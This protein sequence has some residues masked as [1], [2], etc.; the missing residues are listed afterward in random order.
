MIKYEQDNLLP[1]LKR[2][3]ELTEQAESKL[4]GYLKTT[5][6]KPNLY[7]ELMTILYISDNIVEL[8]NPSMTTGEI[9]GLPKAHSGGSKYPVKV[10]KE[11]GWDFSQWYNE[12]VGNIKG[13]IK[14]AIYYYEIEYDK[15]NF[16][17]DASLGK[18]D[19]ILSGIKN[20]LNQVKIY[21]QTVLE[22][23]EKE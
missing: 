9:F 1:D 18:E 14:R 5:Y 2:L 22:M 13:G 17:E 8:F 15:L 3:V 4:E 12:K 20:G 19:F 21:A 6:E 7:R 11:N 16:N 23:T 10:I